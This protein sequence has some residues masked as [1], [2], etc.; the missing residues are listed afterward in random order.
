MKQ[1]KD[2]AFPSDHPFEDSAF[3]SWQQIIRRANEI[4][5]KL[6]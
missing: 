5:E 4:K 1:R 2:L 3:I 6:R